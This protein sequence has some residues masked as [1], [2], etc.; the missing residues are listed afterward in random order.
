MREALEKIGPTRRFTVRELREHVRP[1][2]SSADVWRVVQALTR[3]GYLNLSDD[4]Y[5]LTSLGW[6][7]IEGA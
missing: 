5:R 1:G 4:G 6:T 3:S 2:T 7:W